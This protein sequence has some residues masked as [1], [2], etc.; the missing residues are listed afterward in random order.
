MKRKITRISSCILVLS[1]VFV[2]LFAVV[3]DAF[4]GAVEASYIKQLTSVDT[5]YQNYL[6][7]NTMFRLP[8]TVNDDDLISVIIMLKDPALI[9]TFDKK[10]D[11][12]FLEYY[13]S[14]A[15]EDLRA[16]ISADKKGFLARLEN[17]GI[18][19]TAGAEY[20]TVLSGYE[21][22]LKAKYFEEMCTVLS[23]G[24]RA[25]VGEV[26]NRAET[27]LVE[28]K[29]NVSDTGIFNSTDFK[30][31]G[32]GMVVAVLDTGL[33]YTHDAFD[34]S[35][36]EGKKLGLTIDEVAAVLK[37]TS[38][39]TLRPGLI[40]GDVYVNDKVPFAFD[41]ADFDSDVYSIHSNHGTHVSGV[42]VG[43]NDVIR[44][45]A[46]KAQVVS[47][48][49]FSDT[50]DGAKSSWI[51]N[52]LE[53]CVILGVDV[54]NMSLGTA[55]GFSRATDDEA[56]SGVYDKIRATGI[57]LVVAASNS[58]SSA[59][60]SEK[61]G[62]LGLTSNP[63]TGT[64]GS[65]S[66][67]DAALSVA[68]IMGTKTPYLL[69][70]ETIIY[71]TE[72][73][74]SASKDK[75]FFEEILPVGVDS[76]EFEYVVIPGTGRLADYTD[77]DIE[78]KIA[79]VRRGTT[80]FEQKA[81]AAQT[82]GAAGIIVY[83]NTSGE[84]K[85][86]AGITNIPICSISQ[87]DG[88][89]LAKA[90]GK[91][92][93]SR[94]QSSGPFMSDF[95]SWGPTPDLKIKPEITAH[96]GNILS[97]ITGNQYDRLSGTSMASPNMAGVVALMRQ[98]VLENVPASLYTMENGEIDY[99]AVNAVINRLLMST[100]DIVYNKNGLPYSV[101]KQ[102]AGLGNLTSASTS[103]AMILTYEK[104]TTE[105]GLANAMTKTKLELG[106]DLKKTGK[107]TFTFSVLNFGSTDLSYDI[108]A[109]VMT[110][111][112]SETP[113]Y[114]GD[115]V[116]TNEGY[117]L[118]GATISIDKVVGSTAN[119]T[120]VTVGGGKTVDITMTITLSD[121]DK[122]YLDESFE[123]GMYVEGF[124]NLVA[125][126]GT[127]IDLSVP[128]LAFYGDWTV[129]P[130][131]DL[132]YFETY[133]DELDDSIATLDKTL[134]DSYATRPIGGV[135]NDYISYLGAY[136]FV[137]KPGDKLI[138]AE[139]EHVAISNSVGSVHSIAYIW[140]G[141]LRNA[142]KAVI[143]IYDAST[144][145]VVY[146]R[147]E[148]DIRKSFGDGGTIRPAS[149]D[150]EFDAIEHNLK[151]NTQYNVR[152]QGYVDYGDGG[153][154]TNENCVFEFP[155]T[156]DF[157]AP[158]VTGVEYY[159]EYDRDAK[160]NRLYA[161]F[162]VYDN[163]YAMALQVGYLSDAEAG[164]EYANQ[165]NSF[166]NYLTP[167]YSE[168][169]SK[170]YV[171]YELT[172]YI[173]E[174]KE[175][176]NR[177]NN[178]AVSIYD[179][180]LN[181]S[182]FEI[183]LP[184]DYTDFYVEN[185][186]IVLNPF[187]LYTITPLVYPNTEWP[188]LLTYTTSNDKVAKV[189]NNKI[190]AVGSGKATI[191]IYDPNTSKEIT[192]NVTVRAEGDEGYKQMTQPVADIFEI[193][194]YKTLKAYY[195]LSSS[196]RDIGDTGNIRSFD[197]NLSLTM[198]PSESVRLITRLNEY[199]S[200]VTEI[201]YISGNEKI[202]KVDEN[203]VIVAQAEGYAN[204]TVRLKMNGK[205]TNM[206][207]TVR[208]EVK[209]PYIRTGPWLTNYFGMGGIVE[210]PADLMFTEI[211][212]YAF[213]NYE[214]VPKE[215][216]EID[217]EDPSTTKPQHIGENTITKVI[218][219]EGV[220]K[221]GAYAFA[222][223]TALEEVVLPST[224]KYIEYGAFLGCKNLKTVTGI[225]NVITI[226]KNAFDGCDLRG[227]ISLSSA[228][229][230]ADY[231]FANNKN[232]EG[233]VIPETLRSIGSYAFA[234]NAA[235]KDVTVN[236]AKIKIGEGAFYYCKSLE[237]FSINANV[238]PNAVFAGC[239]KLT[240]INIGKD[241]NAI[242]E[243][244]FSFTKIETFNI[245]SANPNYATIKDG[246]AITN[247]AGDTLVLVAP[248]VSGSFTLSGITKIG[249]GA[250]SGNNAITAVIMQDVT[251]VDNYAFADCVNLSHI[252]LGKLS[253]IGDYS[254]ANIPITTLPTF[255]DDLTEIG[256]YAFAYS[257]LLFVT[258]PE[259]MTVGEGAFTECRY[260]NTVV[261][262]DNVNLGYGAFMLN[263]DV[264][265]PRTGLYNYKYESYYHNGKLVYGFTYTSAL[266]NLTIGNNVNIGDHAFAGAAKIILVNLGENAIIGDYAFFNAANLQTID[267]SK[268]LSIGEAAFSGDV[269][270]QFT[271]P[272]QNNYYVDMENRTY[273]FRYYSPSFTSVNLSAATEI[274]MG[275]FAGCQKLQ[276]VVL[277]EGIDTIYENTFST[278]V[279]LKSIN[280]E[281]VD[282]VKANAFV[283]CAFENLDLGNVTTIEPYSFVYC[284]ELK[285]LKLNPEK[286]NI[287]EGAFAYCG[288]LTT[289]ENLNKAESIGAYAFAY[290]A[291]T[292]IDLSG[293]IRV[294]DHAFIKESYTGITL[295]LGEKLEYLGDNPFAYCY[296][297]PFST[298]VVETFNG[299]DYTSI[300][301]TYD[302][303]ETVK[304][305][306]GSLYCVVP[307][308][309]E[310]IT[311]IKNDS[312]VVDV[313]EGVVRISAFAFACSDVTRVT[314]PH[315]LNAIGHKA[316]YECGKLS[317][318]VFKS[319][320][321]PVLEE[322]FD[323]NYFATFENLAGSGDY[324]FTY[325]D[326]SVTTIPGLGII[327][328][329]M[330]DAGASYAGTYYGANFVDY[331]G[332]YEPSLVMIAPSNGV[333]Y[334]SFLYSCYFNTIIEGGVAADDT[335]LA[336]ID[337]IN[338][339]PKPVLLEHEALVIAARAAYDK[340]ASLE[341]KALVYNYSDLLS[342]ET[343]IQ[344]FK[345]T[346]ST[347]EPEIDDPIDDPNPVKDGGKTALI[348]I[349]IIESV[350]IA[351]A[352]GA[353]VWYFLLRKKNGSAPEPTEAA[354]TEEATEEVTE[355]AP[356]EE[357]TEEAAA[358]D[359]T[360]EA[361]AEEAPTEEATEDTATEEAPADQTEEN[362]TEKKED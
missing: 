93:I 270:Y 281:N 122:K 318:V 239:E 6:D 348:V 83:N 138:A 344:A 223:L 27:Q 16:R 108:S 103:S 192:V 232:L 17:L 169:N 87:D 306:N 144:G 85:M 214:Y 308:G 357:A 217:D 218:I 132:D 135:E 277:G 164:S 141:L 36:M 295:K 40:A 86:N 324:D 113:T 254:F 279:A 114:K 125:K 235:L 35:K 263:R 150:V 300:S 13:E 117:I 111:G 69:F 336:A 168:R 4:G 264:V 234:N 353:A 88:E 24:A 74:N 259:G 184:A 266:T 8:S 143:T 76:M 25:I 236:A 89:M 120:T 354:P 346:G 7:G 286:S 202:V 278:C 313:P 148:N 206:T 146:E 315:T 320:E 195:R 360:E 268:A 245:D 118:E 238:I 71:F 41:Y 230:I 190:V 2:M 33:D 73:A 329:K 177:P 293:A 81:N 54:I 205:N 330:L 123:N 39:T 256:K 109:I 347:D 98:Y 211:S 210:I 175:K 133:E 171:T 170:T 57:S 338:R 173:Y 241:V 319:Y 294:D 90:N 260:L 350:L 334:D 215:E 70:G 94:D 316:F 5:Q 65:P 129:A 233:V 242:S 68:S 147:V 51:L 208:V 282:T 222:K 345:N 142:A 285:T 23:N 303:S 275:A 179:Y 301:Y 153:L 110:E 178:L 327:P 104:G 225:E 62:N 151:N 34:P 127:D 361:P 162:E 15:G 228:H 11:M 289:V 43:D 221:I 185:T 30:Y 342:A 317:A 67:Y 38:A 248:T 55:C 91:I 158:A 213:S 79:L 247:K 22:T 77:M 237:S 265:H 49:V 155:F 267:L 157:L 250:F 352:A 53:D 197:G 305:I 284:E 290:T 1:L 60:G 343:R 216:W 322:E 52:A 131:F 64:V 163:H 307:D 124:V 20:D 101:R 112:V 174:I 227:T 137:Q 97:A 37:N 134:P 136:Y 18:N 10:S 145:E 198:F 252:K 106:D 231:A 119:G 31:D 280:L 187:E 116:V 249:Q 203:G 340:I 99:V 193:S 58:Y 199:F 299:T 186:D 130:L 220:E 165:L 78:G 302:I 19:Y 240:E 42:I 226:N 323:Q 291:L 46:P 362:S 66:T 288:K 258:I 159:T 331:I 172:D 325:T 44:G 139:R 189:V 276:S 355:E 63:D 204:I 359:V 161:K 274:G 229:A 337:A 314:L 126:S 292:D 180:A 183:P 128:Y 194:G 335:T 304:V 251:A 261:I 107:Y 246:K 287:G 200:D 45:V 140:A 328:Y 356:T 100:A 351:G 96:G 47:M 297:A 253:Y 271:D 149:I 50:Q 14:E 312:T 82:A 181:Y 95:S 283:Y 152:V 188:E 339:M 156:T 105:F 32:E 26:Y 160:K 269:L 84:I 349:V 255:A 224:L 341:Q 196:D 9:D 80:T 12:T 310:L 212:Q 21:I 262:G 176:S 59:Q 333:Y 298:T 92:K 102:G 296:M 48:K 154:T 56:I 209:D 332:H 257:D 121:A 358:E 191:F 219:P 182:I 29:V 272:Y 321:A 75:N 72:A 3:S 309:L 326:G 207:K 243:Y 115:T 61:N 311:Y 201:V 167:I 28:N 166:S 244:A 273:I